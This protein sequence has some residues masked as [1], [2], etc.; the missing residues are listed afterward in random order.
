MSTD[1][2]ATVVLCD[3]AQ[4]TGGKLYVLGGGWTRLRANTPA[5]IALGIV[6]HIPW[7]RANHKIRFEAVLR[8]DDGEAVEMNDTQVR[9]TGEFEVGRPPGMKQGEQI[10]FPLVMSFNGLALPAGGYVW[11][12]EIDGDV[13]TRCPFRAG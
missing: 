8:N 10:N 5:N 3:A 9:G 13:V 6:V 2:Q 4:A 1:L 11:E 7:D 12:C